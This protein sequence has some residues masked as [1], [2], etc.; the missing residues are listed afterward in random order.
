MKYCI[1]LIFSMLALL[2]SGQQPVDSNVVL[3]EKEFLSIVSKYHPV[4]KKIRMIAQEAGGRIFTAKG[5]FDPRLS[6]DLDAKQY[7]DKQYYNLINSELVLPSWYGLEFKGGY[8]VSR[9]K[10]LNQQEIL[11]ENGLGSI[12]ASWQILQG[13]LMDERRAALKRAKL[14]QQY[15][16]DQQK[17]EMNEL[18]FKANNAY[19][20]WATAYYQKEI[21]DQAAEIAK[22]RFEFVKASHF[23]GE[24]AAIDT[25]EALI[26]WQNRQLEQSISEIELQKSKFLLAN[27]LWLDNDTPVD[28]TDKVK[29]LPIANVKPDNTIFTDFRANLETSVLE[30]PLIRLYDFKLSDLDIERRLKAE[31]LKPKLKLSYSLLGEQF[32][33]L[34]DKNNAGI[35]LPNNYKWQLGFG[36]PLFLRSARGDLQLQD[37]K[38]RQ[39]KYDL[40]LKRQELTNKTRS[41]LQQLD[42]NI[43]QIE[44]FNKTLSNYKKLFDAETQKLTIGESNLFLVNSRENKLIEADVKKTELMLKHKLIVAELSLVLGDMSLILQ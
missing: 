29:P 20:L 44:L 38:I 43:L 3:T 12:G 18:L 39:T 6:F 22:S 30:N 4:T 35:I 33:I 25:V 26:Q 41:Y 37:I 11:P 2:V 31:K 36:F 14:F 28:I 8:A 10:F 16:V 27:F 9:G 21:F 17:A 19:W 13:F 5:Q 24:F 42:N 40:S 15:V 23:L 32:D 34:E 1:L 7:D